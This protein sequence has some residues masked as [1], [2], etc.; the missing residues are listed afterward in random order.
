M[1]LDCPQRGQGPLCP[2]Y[3]L[4][5]ASAS[6][7]LWWTTK[8]WVP[9]FPSLV[10]LLSLGW[11]SG[12]P[13]DVGRFP[14]P[15]LSHPVLQAVSLGLSPLFPLFFSLSC[16]SQSL[17]PT[18]AAAELRR[19]SPAGGLVVFLHCG[20]DSARRKSPRKAPSFSSIIPWCC[21]S[22]VQTIPAGLG[23]RIGASLWMLG[24]EQAAGAAPS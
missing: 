21:H 5:L 13:R 9:A 20:R 6:P 11:G 23:G 4:S 22:A 19:V 3:T 7:P 8:S 12:M 18:F 14:S 16:V 10:A 24:S 2:C 1:A 15:Q 17:Y